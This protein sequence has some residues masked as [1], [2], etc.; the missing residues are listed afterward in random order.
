[1]SGLWRPGYP[2]SYSTS[3]FK[4]FWEPLSTQQDYNNMH[5]HIQHMKQVLSCRDL[6]QQS[7]TQVVNGL[8]LPLR[9][10]RLERDC[11]GF[12]HA[13]WNRQQHSVSLENAGTACLCW[14]GMDF[15]SY[16]HHCR[17]KE[18]SSS[19]TVTVLHYQLH[20]YSSKVHFLKENSKI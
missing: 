6:V 7:K 5:T 15:H 4:G 12:E 8:L 18:S 9:E 3:S 13:Q 17:N 1:M 11:L 16:T 2:L 19:L 14:V 10:G 20:P